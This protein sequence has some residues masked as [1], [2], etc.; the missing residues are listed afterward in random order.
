LSGEFFSAKCCWTEVGC[1]YE[2]VLETMLMRKNLSGGQKNM[3]AKKLIAPIVITII[4]VLLFCSAFI[5]IFFIDGVSASDFHWLEI[6]LIC[7]IPLLLAGVSIYV[8]I[9]RIKEVRSG[10]ED[11]LGKY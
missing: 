6:V 7:G 4:M 5:P 2:T 9:E 11:D 3:Y 8:L 10:E 1:T